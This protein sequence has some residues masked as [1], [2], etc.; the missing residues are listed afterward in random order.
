MA[1]KF[2]YIAPQNASN[3]TSL[4]ANLRANFE[5]IAEAL[6]KAVS[7]DGDGP[8]FMWADLD[9]NGYR[10]ININTEDQGDEGL[11]KRRELGFI[12][13]GEFR[14]NAGTG[15]LE[16]REPGEGSWSVLF[17][18]AE[19][20]GPEGAPGTDG[21]D[22]SSTGDL[23]AANNLGDVADRAQAVDNLGLSKV[24]G[25]DPI[26]KAEKT[27]PRFTRFRVVDTTQSMAMNDEG[28]MYRPGLGTLDLTVP[29]SGDGSVRTV[30]V[31]PS[32]DGARIVPGT[33]GVELF[34][35]GQTTPVTSVSLDPGAF[36]SVVCVSSD[37][38]KFLVA[39][40]G[41]R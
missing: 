32:A 13:A 12:K 27:D 9:L 19:L 15:D 37:G 24:D 28:H 4:E 10:I 8:N 38:T 17:T 3:P 31:R 39:G 21:A 5:N 26:D 14:K 1:I 20:K 6:D 34:L 16:Y 11:V 29:V 36:V 18:A 30:Y 22:G 33:G 40:T 35:A 23:L 7:R 25:F 2:E 41:I